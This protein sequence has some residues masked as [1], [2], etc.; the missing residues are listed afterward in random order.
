MNK[1]QRESIQGIIDRLEDL[2]L[3]YEI[4]IIREDEK[5]VEKVITNIPDSLRSSEHYE[6][7]DSAVDGLE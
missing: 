7:S 3:R 4:K 5:E 1:A 6:I 2:K